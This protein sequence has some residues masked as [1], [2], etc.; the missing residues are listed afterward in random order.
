MEAIRNRREELQEEQRWRELDQRREKERR[1]EEE[2]MKC[3][4]IG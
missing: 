4:F 1:M 2:S 3:H